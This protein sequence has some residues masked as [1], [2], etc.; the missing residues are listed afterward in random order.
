M[1]QITKA[2]LLEK[3]DK[4]RLFSQKLIPDTSLEIIGVRVPKIKQIVK[5]FA[6]TECAYNFI[7]ENHKY[8]EEYFVHGLLIGTI[9]NDI[10]QVFK[11]LEDFLPHLDNW[12]ICDSTV[13]NLEIF[14]KHKELT[15]KK[16]LDYLKFNNPYTVRFGVIILLDYFLDDGFNEN[17]I[18]ALLNVKSEHY[19]VNMAIAWFIS[20]ALVKQ[21][22]T[23]IKYIENKLFPKFVH[24]KA[25][26][27]A[28]ESFRISSD[29]K[30]YLNTLK[31]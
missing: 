18:N 22:D 2:L 28:K 17:V 10:Q 6:N 19:Y 13:A 15:H 30:V 16:A 7:R 27:K 9:K 20:V 31:I 5:Q 12:A 11:M 4:Y 23:M 14:K 8:Y 3:D 29:V 26:Q 24:N 1:N 25:I 21:Y